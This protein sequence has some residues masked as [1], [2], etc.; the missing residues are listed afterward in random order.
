MDKRDPIPWFLF[1]VAI[2]IL[3]CLGICN[4]V[5]KDQCEARGGRVV[6]VEG[7][8]FTWICDDGRYRP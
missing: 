6:D 1:L 2:A 4:E 7:Q 8:A 5:R 3:G